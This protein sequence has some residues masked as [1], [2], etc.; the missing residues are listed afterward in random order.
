MSVKRLR[1]RWRVDAR[2][3]LDFDSRSDAA[4]ADARARRVLARLRDDLENPA[5]RC[6]IAQHLDEFLEEIRLGIDRR[7]ACSVTTVARHRARLLAFS[8][9]WPGRTLDAIGRRDVAL[10]IKSRM[11]GKKRVRPHTVNLDLASLRLFARWAHERGHAPENPDLVRLRPVAAKGRVAGNNAP[12]RFLAPP[13]LRDMLAAFGAERPDIGLVLE[14]M[15]YFGLRPRALVDSRW[16]HVARPRGGHAGYY[17]PPVI[18]GGK[19]TAIPI[20]PDSV[21][22]QW[23]DRCAELWRR[24][25]GKKKPGR[26]SPLLP[27]Q[28]VGWDGDRPDADNRARIR[29]RRRPRPM[30]NPGG[31]TTD[32][33]CR[34][35]RKAVGERRFGLP[36]DAALTPYT[37][38]HSMMMWLKDQPGISAND[39][40]RYAGHRRATT[41]E[42]YVQALAAGGDDTVY[43]AAQCIAPPP[44]RRPEEDDAED[45]SGDFD[46]FGTSEMEEG[47][48]GNSE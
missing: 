33:L 41:Q 1:G 40:Q 45:D 7:V 11:S 21:A 48:D 5:P 29:R 31:W 17:L 20:H 25:T 9:A 27:A 4:A 34:Q 42:F 13:R 32:R 44:P 15:C 26:S 12:P 16:S 30:R 6:T 46:T 43:D 10:W 35:F 36:G 2:I 3:A 18:K 14:G 23:L 37:V 8:A 19:N 28:P 47:D 22:A 38:R 39:R 24:Y